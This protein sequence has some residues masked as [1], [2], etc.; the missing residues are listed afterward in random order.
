MRGIGVAI[1]LQ[2]GLGLTSPTMADDHDANPDEQ[3]AAITNML[4]R[5]QTALR[6]FCWITH[7]EFRLNGQA[8]SV[9]QH[10]CRYGP[11]GTVYR[12]PLGAPPPKSEPRG[13][14]RRVLE[15]GADETQDSIDAA[16][17][18]TSSYVLP[19]PQRLEALYQSANAIFVKRPGS[20]LTHLEIRDYLKPGDLLVIG[21]DPETNAL[22]SIDV[23]SYLTDQADTATL[24]ARFETLPDGTSYVASSVV[25][26][27]VRQLQ[28]IT[29]NVSYRRVWQ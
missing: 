28:V 16:L 22:R 1:A 7:T 9:S 23:A 12:T 6:Q 4:V 19:M 25:N 15:I 26:A 21:F 5:Q 18:L 2:F 27:A 14:R 24:Q 17:T 3:F 11:D 29:E 8:T 10:L 20:S 13:L